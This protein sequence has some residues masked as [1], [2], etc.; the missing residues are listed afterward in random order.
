MYSTI[1]LVRYD[2]KCKIFTA[3]FSK[4]SL[5][6]LRVFVIMYGVF[7]VETYHYFYHDCS[8]ALDCCMEKYCCPDENTGRRRC[9]ETCHCNSDDDCVSQHCCNPYSKCVESGCATA[10]SKLPIGVIILS[11]I[12]SIILLL[13]IVLWCYWQREGGWCNRSRSNRN[14]QRAQ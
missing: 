5:L 13:L 7:R 9:S 14:S 6:F 10:I 3:T 2:A 8:S 4:M 12:L 1:T 11:I